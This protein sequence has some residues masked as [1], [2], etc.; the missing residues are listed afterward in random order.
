MKNSF[1]KIIIA[2]VFCLAPFVVSASS[3]GNIS[4]YAWSDNIGWI[5]FNC[6]NLDTCGTG[7]GKADYGV[8]KE[9]DGSLMGYAWSPNVGWIKFGELSGFPSS[10]GQ[11]AQVVGDNLT[12]WARVCS[13]TLS[14]NCSTM[15]SR[16]DG[17]DGWISLAGT[18]YGVSFDGSAFSGYAWGSEVMGWIS[19][20][21]VTTIPTTLDTLTASDCIIDPAI[22]PAA[23]SCDTTI[24]WNVPNPGVVNGSTVTSSYPIAN[25]TVYSGDTGSNKSVTIPYSNRTFYLYNGGVEPPL[26]SITVKA[27]C[28]TGTHWDFATTKC[29][30][31]SVDGYYSDWGACDVSC[32][33]TAI[34][35]IPPQPGGLD[36]E[37]PAPTQPCT[38]GACVAG[39]TCSPPMKH[40][41]CDGDDASTNSGTSQ[42]SSPSRYTWTCGTTT[43]CFEKKSSSVKEN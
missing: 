39:G 4:G 37:L 24:S 9:S 1:L 2:L 38:G 3:S 15:D 5:S 30:T 7:V 31:T 22:N 43:T 8:N 17:W 14:G 32:H 25:T 11:N 10:P 35:C 13:G 36:C 33:Q 29:V 41:K 19:F 6:T 18:G 40:Y 34:T 26:A 20:S 21:G 27:T 42:K 16:T 12:G 23:N 28:K